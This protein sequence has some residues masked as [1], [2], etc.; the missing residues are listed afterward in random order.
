MPDTGTHTRSFFFHMNKPASLKM[1]RPVVS[2]HYC[3]KCY[4]VNN[5][6][7]NTPTRGRLRKKQPVFVMVGKARSVRIV[8]GVAFID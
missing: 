3:G 1:G 7:C 8:D 5:V 4:L 2:L 6:V